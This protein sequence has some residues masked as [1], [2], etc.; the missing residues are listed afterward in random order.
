MGNVQLLDKTRKIGRFLHNNNADMVVFDDMCRVMTQILES[1]VLV[2]SKKGK[3]LGVGLRN[4]IDEIKE[5]L[6]GKVGAFID[7]AVNERCLSVLSTQENVNLATLG[8][9]KT[10]AAK[11]RTIVT[12]VEISG[13]RLGT[14]FL[15]KSSGEYDIDDIILAEYCVTVVGLEMLRSVNEEN[16][17]EERKHQM[18][19]AAFGTLSVSEKDAMIHIFDALN[20]TE[21]ILVA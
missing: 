10:S 20:G 6:S 11:Y 18:V 19:Q 3:V 9:G 5:H 14:L 17:E 15:Y 13:E 7:R 12:P 16:A 8:F 2:I 1:N 21:G 4:D